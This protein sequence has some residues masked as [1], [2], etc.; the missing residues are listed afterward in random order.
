MLRNFEDVRVTAHIELCSLLGGVPLILSLSQDERLGI[1][2]TPLAGLA[3]SYRPL[4]PESG[5]SHRQRSEQ[6]WRRL[7]TTGGLSWP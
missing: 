1:A 2:N 7:R 4:Q 5:A 6:Q 3:D